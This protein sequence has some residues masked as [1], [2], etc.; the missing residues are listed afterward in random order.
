L[1]YLGD[2][3]PASTAIFVAQLADPTFLLEVEVVAARSHIA[4]T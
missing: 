1:K 3:Q 4:T 2:H